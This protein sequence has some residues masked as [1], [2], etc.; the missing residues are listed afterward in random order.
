MAQIENI[1]IRWDLSP[2]LITIL[3]PTIEATV[4]DIYD[5]LR[6]HEQRITNLIYPSIISAGGGENL[7]GGTTVGITA[8]LQNAQI[9]F[10]ARYIRT[11]D[12]YA[13]VSGATGGITLIDDN[14]TFISDGVERGA[15]ITNFYDESYASVT[16]IISETELQIDP[17]TDGINNDWEI[18]DIYKVHNEIQCRVSGGNL[19]AIDDVGGDI[20]SISPTAFVQIIL[21][22]SSSAT[23][24][25]IQDI[26]YSSFGG[27]VT[28]DLTSSFS[29]IVY[30]TGT[31]RQPVNNFLDALTIKTIRGFTK[32][33]I[34]GDATID[35]GL[36]YNGLIFEGESST[37]SEFTI[38]SAAD[39]L[40]CEFNNATVTG[41]LDGYS[42]IR[43]CVIQDLEFFDGF[44]Y[45]SIL[46][47]TINLSGDQPSFIINCNSGIAGSLTPTIDMGGSGSSLV[48][49]KYDGGIKLINKNGPD[50]VSI[51]LARGQVILDS[52]VTAGEILIRGIGKLTD[53]STADV[54]AT[55]LLQGAILQQQSA[56]TKYLI[57]DLRGHHSGVGE[58]YYWNPINGS[59]TN[60]GLLPE[61]ALKTFQYIHDNMIIDG[62]H[63]VIH[64]VGA[65]GSGPSIVSEFL[66]ITKNWFF[67]RGPGRDI[68][69]QA[70]NDTRPA[71]T[72]D[73]TG[74]EIFGMQILS[75]GGA[76]QPAIEVAST[77][78]FI[79]IASVWL[80]GS[81]G[82][83]FTILGGDKHIVSDCHFEAT[84]GYAINIIDGYHCSIDNNDIFDCNVGI[85]LSALNL[86]VDSHG[87]ILRGNSVRES[88]TG[89]GIEIGYNVSETLIRI[90]NYVSPTSPIIDNGTG[91]H[92]EANEVSS[93]NSTATSNKI[94]QKL[95]PFIA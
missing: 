46:S 29:G 23:S 54:D 91:T 67:I 8:T 3:S 6:D 50:K 82:N 58:H 63:D 30:P 43:D 56:Q 90:T 55:D 78:S 89:K 34:R 75:N 18:G 70:P 60:D 84:D 52:T 20:S 9:A 14:A 57:E 68:A 39:V 95:F 86:T 71:I 47:G 49:R 15:T 2:R 42:V 4:Q 12:G 64:I 17:L 27:G 25:N 35:A 31:P 10:E 65:V 5:T 73:A 16:K 85:Y 51:D 26:E 41:V 74:V 32:F 94:F 80:E 69:I 21:A 92:I 62:N 33:Y 53:N 77:S 7:G 81:T 72:I 28:V 19:V 48:L 66:T 83:G 40:G 45:D 59:D 13:T 22:N 36:L 38:T 76:S 1:V 93:T 44:I 37:R 11:S 24:Q 79:K 61:T 87:S 88:L